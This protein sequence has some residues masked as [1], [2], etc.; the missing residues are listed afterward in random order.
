M[1]W[2]QHLN[3]HPHTGRERSV[4]L[5][6]LLLFLSTEQGEGQGWDS[7]AVVMLGER[8]GWWQVGEDCSQR[9]WA[10]KSV[11]GIDPSWWWSWE[12]QEC[13]EAVGFGEGTA[14]CPKHSVR[15][16]GGMRLEGMG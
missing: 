10:Q 1:I 3:I 15:D 11:F 4:S 9:S 5:S 6:S 8:G 16:E 2:G 12:Y 14:C 13:K 7:W